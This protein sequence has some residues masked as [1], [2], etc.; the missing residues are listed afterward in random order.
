MSETP[1]NAGSLRAYARR[2]KA[3]GLPGGSHQSVAR[4]IAQGRLRASVGV[5]PDGQPGITDFALADQEW[6]EN[7]DLTKA[8]G[9]LKDWAG[10]E[11]DDGIESDD[12]E[13][14]SSVRTA[15]AREKHWKARLAELNYKQRAGELVNATET[16]A[17]WS[18]FCSLVRSKCLALP[19]KMKQRCPHLTLEDLATLDQEVRDILTA[20]ATDDTDDGE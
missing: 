5:G 6:A 3:H 14:H 7:T 8:P 13:D 15:S 18:D 2:R 9:Y 16:A 4:A 12:P 1:P 11:G 20:L 17:V 10:G 19:S